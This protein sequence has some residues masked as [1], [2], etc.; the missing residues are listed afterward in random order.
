MK[1]KKGEIVILIDRGI[2]PPF[3]RLQVEKYFGSE[4]EIKDTP[5]NDHYPGCYIINPPDGKIFIA[6]EFELKKKPDAREWFNK[7]IKIPEM[8]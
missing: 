4:V 3:F 7:N 6:L 2:T 5:G 1:F 8:A